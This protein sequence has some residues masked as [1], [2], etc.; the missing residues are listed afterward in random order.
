MGDFI[1]WGTL[2]TYGGAL[3]MV[4]ILTQ[5]TKGLGFIKKIPTQIWTYIL[6]LIVL[7]PAVYFTGGLT[8]E[9]IAET[10]FNGVIVSIAANGGYQGVKKIQESIN[11][12]DK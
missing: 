2:V 11:S 10:F 8:A 3:A 12:L 7:F 6:A 5:F 9:K 1:S 4:V